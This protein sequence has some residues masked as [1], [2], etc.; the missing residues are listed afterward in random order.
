[1]SLEIKKAAVLGAGVM[2]A[3]IAAHLTNAGI[4][5]YLLDIIPFELTEDDKKKGLTEKSPAW[6]NRFAE[7]GL[8]AA[9]KSKP[10]SFYSKK[11]ASM[12]KTGNFEDDLKL[13]ADCD[14]V[15]E[16]VVENLKIKQE[17]FAKVEKVVKP[18]C[19]VS[20][21]TS[22][23]PIKDISA[24]FSPS[25]KKRFLG[26]HF[27]NPPRYMK[28][29]E[30][31]PGK[32]TDPEI[33]AFMKKFGE[34]VLGKGVV[35]CKDVPNFIGNRIGVYDLCNAQ[36]VMVE[37]GMKIEE[38]DAIVGKV[39]GRPGTA[40]FGT[41]DLVGLD[42]G[43]HVSKNLYD[44]VPDDECRDTFLPLDFQGKMMANKWLGNKTKGGF[45]KKVKDENGKNVKYAL[46]WKTMEYKVA[47]KPKFESISEAKKWVDFGVANSMKVAFNG[48]DAAAD[49]LREYL[50]NNFIYAA[51][52]VPEICDTIVEI[53]N[54]MKWGYNHQLGPFES[55]D[56]IGVKEVVD[57]MKKLGKK[58]PAKVEEMLA[59]GCASFYKKDADGT[60]YYY[61]FEKKG[62][63]K[64]EENPKIIFLPSLK[65]RKK[66]VKE[67]VAATLVD[68]GDGVVCLEFHTKM[69]AIDADMI[70]M[71]SDS[72]DIVNK[73]F[74]GMVVANHDQRM[75]SAGANIFAV[76][77]AIQQGQWDELEKMVAALQNANM[78]MK[79]LPKPVVTAPAGMA[80][81]GGC[82]IS[83]HGDY[84]LANGETY[85]GLVEVGVGVIPAGGGC[86]EL[87]I[88]MT[89]GIPAGVVEAGLNMQ[90][91]YGKAFE[92]IA[93]AKVATSAQEAQELGF[94]RT[95]CAINMSRDMQIYEAKQIVLGLA[96]FYKP[97][98]PAL[99]PVMGE[100]LKG[101][102]AAIIGNMKAGKY[103]SDYDAHIAMKVAHVLGGGTCAEGTWVTEQEMLDLEREAFMSLCGEK[104]TQDRINAML[105]T[106]KPLR[107]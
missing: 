75:F 26:T 98:K 53:D 85:M 72:C 19:I 4:E 70:Q 11:N 25:L 54:A 81:G 87:A 80:L 31:I 56:A 7:N 84:C 79:Y 57:V 24:N 60:K 22:G 32:E 45:Y 107:N 38:V 62:Y 48:Q 14:W 101:V 47:E 64:L 104:K 36:K 3:N 58:V 83:M 2:G 41:M 39:V 100:N 97:P 30:I 28:L 21:N 103:A 5:C 34:E 88:R 13:L 66:V 92:N 12:I 82:E 68:I 6:R 1:M 37:K 51:N 18:T 55:W 95:N 59:K 50:C 9:V 99:I 106:G 67:N 61:D 17:L 10:A 76:L 105:T 91:H 49:Y 33:V 44:A 94:I 74:A 89:E 78:K 93:T 15:C 16:V 65:E 20:T 71:I 29:L 23:L 63:V 52:R 43:A 96:K 8:A 42:I 35:I 102:A 90:Y 27:F 73:D 77:I 46:D 69:N 86:K 40:I